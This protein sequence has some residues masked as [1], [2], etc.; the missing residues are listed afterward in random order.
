MIPWTRLNY[1]SRWNQPL[2]LLIQLTICPS[3]D[4]RAERT[5]LYISTWPSAIRQKGSTGSPSGYSS[6]QFLQS[7]NREPEIKISIFGHPKSI[8]TAHTRGYSLVCSR[9]ALLQMVGIEWPVN[10]YC[11][12]EIEISILGVQ[13]LFRPLT[14]GDAL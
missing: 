8:P 11:S 12:T 1:A 5:P 7:F 6:P 2:P 10:S 3:S 13:N 14:S 4:L 9:N